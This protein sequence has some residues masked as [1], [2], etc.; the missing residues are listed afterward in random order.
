MRKNQKR[1]NISGTVRALNPG[2]SVT[3]SREE[4]RPTYLRV[5]TSCLAEDF[6]VRFTVNKTGEGTYK[7]TRHE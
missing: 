6:G 7:V 2:E 3:F 4:A 1:R 5:L